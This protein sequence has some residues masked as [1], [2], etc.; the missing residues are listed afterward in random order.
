[1]EEVVVGTAGVEEAEEL[2]ETVTVE[3]AT[4][5][6]E[7]VFSGMAVELDTEAGRVD[8]TVTAPAGV[9]PAGFEDDAAAWEEELCGPP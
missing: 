7:L 5:A 4:A 6:L 3:T 8:V 2:E 1:M 9:L